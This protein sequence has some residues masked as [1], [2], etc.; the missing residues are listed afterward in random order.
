MI[1]IN[2]KPNIGKR[3]FAGIIDYGIII[4]IYSAFTP[5]FDEL[6]P[7]LNFDINIDALLILIGLWLIFTV[8]IEIQFGKTLGNSLFGLKAIPI[9]GENRKLFFRESLLR[10]LLDPIDMFFFGIVGIVSISLSE[11]NQRLGDILAK[12]IVVNTKTINK[13]K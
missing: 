10:H 2:T 12:T 1:L 3:I 13:S 8:G 9:S 4:L 6:D 7:E 5:F 11:K